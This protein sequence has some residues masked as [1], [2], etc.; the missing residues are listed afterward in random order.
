ML[1]LFLV[2]ITVLACSIPD[3]NYIVSY[4]N[5]RRRLLFIPLSFG[6]PPSNFGLSPRSFRLS[7]DNLWVIDYFSLCRCSSVIGEFNFYLPF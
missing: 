7:P 4:M 1:L 5:T 3:W 2:I 6:L